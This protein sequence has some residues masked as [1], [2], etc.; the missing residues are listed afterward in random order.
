MS[1]SLPGAEDLR[2]AADQLAARLPHGL[3]PLA[4]VAYNYRWS[5]LADGERLFA[6]VDPD[7]WEMCGHNPVRLLQEAP[8]AAL[9][10]A[11]SNADLAFG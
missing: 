11:A 3:A 8:S 4:R 10:R 9:W 7:R 2:R 1:A 5:W 6:E